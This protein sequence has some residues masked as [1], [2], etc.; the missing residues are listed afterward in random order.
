MY[1]QAHSR[2]IGPL[3]A[4]GRFDEARREAEIVLRLT[5]NSATAVAGLATIDAEAGRTTDARRGLAS[6]LER[7][8]TEYVP[9][10]AVGAVYAKLGDTINQDIWLMRAYE[11]HSNAM[12]YLLVDT[13]RVWHT[14]ATVVK[15]IAAVGLR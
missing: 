13:A 2:L 6:L 9:P 15:L 7:A 1:V 12:A 14:D 4:L 10:G 11:E 8:R 5:N 3:A